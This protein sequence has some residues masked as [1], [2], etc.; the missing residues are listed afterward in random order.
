MDFLDLVKAAC[1][2]SGLVSSQQLPT[3]VVGLVGRKLKI[4]NAVVDAWDSIQTGRSDW[5][6][7]RD[8][9]T[10]ALIIGQGSYTPAQ[11]GIAMRFRSFIPDKPDF[12]PVTLYDPAIGQADETALCQISRFDWRTMYDRG[13]QT[14]TRP[15]HYAIDNGKLLVGPLP[16][17][18]YTLRGSYM[19]AAQV[20]T[21]DADVPEL[22]VDYH[23]LIKW[24]AIMTVH[25]LDGAF[26]DRTVAQAEYSRM[27]RLL[28]NEQTDPVVVG[29]TLC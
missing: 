12:Q 11:L 9:Y 15:V 23:P 17:K 8:V 18:T 26:A 1:L 27:Y 29:G 5:A 6:W 2:D 10:H 22:P 16:D 13:V 3:T 7:M 21:V 25:G 28:A 19:K 14:N 4:M 20:L 24:R